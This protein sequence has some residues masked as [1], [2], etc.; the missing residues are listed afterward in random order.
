MGINIKLRRIELGIKQKDLAGKLGISKQYLSNLE[1]G[2]NKNPNRQ[3]MID[4]AIALETDVQ[5]LFFSEEK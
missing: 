5:T 1:T 2:R 3:L 4:I